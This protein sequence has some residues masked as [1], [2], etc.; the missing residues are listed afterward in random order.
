MT[1][2]T[3]QLADKVVQVSALTPDLK[4]FL[5][6]YLCDLS[7]EIEVEVTE[8]DIEKE[9]QLERQEGMP[10]SIFPQSVAFQRKL[11]TR[12]LDYNILI[13]HGSCIAVDGE[14]CIFTALSGTGKSTHT[15]LWRSLLGSRVTMVNDDKPFIRVDEDGVTA[16]GSPWDGKHHRSSNIAV[17]LKA[18]CLLSRSETNHIS[19][20]AAEE[21][22]PVLFYEQVHH[23]EV[24][25]ATAKVA[26]LLERLCKHVRFY[27]LGCNMEP[28]AAQV[29]YNG[30]FGD[31][32]ASAPH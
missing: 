9:H 29:A 8:E 6:D 15:S 3:V 32:E 16:Y 17:P 18:V 22:F 4:D 26:A 25:E 21:A 12:L 20:I 2:F 23:P 10:L 14:G 28:D 7:P 31:S 19:P 11:S 24:A 5:R 13:M 27:A 30:I 1:R